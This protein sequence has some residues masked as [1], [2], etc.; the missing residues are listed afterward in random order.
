MSNQI[1]VGIDPSM[2]TTGV[3]VYNPADGEM[4]TIAIKTQKGKGHELLDRMRRYREV[5]EKLYSFIK[6]FSPVHIAAIETPS[7]NSKSSSASKLCE[8]GGILRFSLIYPFHHDIRLVDEVAPASWQSFI[9]KASQ[10]DKKRIQDAVEEMTDLTFETDDECDAFCIAWY[11]A[12][13]YGLE[14]PLNKQ[15]EK[16]YRRVVE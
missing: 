16:Y 3:C 4:D 11:T 5:A 6:P 14:E 13:A 12:V 7:F 9:V 8:L 15:Q 1:V 10:P 2:T